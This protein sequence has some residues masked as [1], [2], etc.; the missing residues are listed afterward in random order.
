VATGLTRKSALVRFSDSA[1]GTAV[2]VRAATLAKGLASPIAATRRF[3]PDC[4]V[5]GSPTCW[6]ESR[7]T[8]RG[9]SGDPSSQYHVH[10]LF[11]LRACEP[12]T[13]ACTF[14]P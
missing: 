14:A 5:S 11:D 4:L 3:A 6:R 7:K 10:Y 8:R 13:G 2:S 1:L 12:T 9:S